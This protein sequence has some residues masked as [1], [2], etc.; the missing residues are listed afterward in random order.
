MYILKYI[1]CIEF[2][3]DLYGGDIIQE[4]VDN[5]EECHK[6]CAEV[7]ACNTWTFSSA[8]D[9][10]SLGD[11]ILRNDTNQT[12]VPTRHCKTGFKDSKNIKCAIQGTNKVYSQRFDVILISLTA[13]I[14]L[15]ILLS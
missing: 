10:Y 13:I 11:C 2:D 5:Y 1:A 4:T 15:H 9:K 12:L 8:D 7:S 3:H 6:R 14:N